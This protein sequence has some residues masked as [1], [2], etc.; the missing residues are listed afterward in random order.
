MLHNHIDEAGKTAPHLNFKSGGDDVSGEYL[1]GKLA[2]QRLT[3]IVCRSAGRRGGSGRPERVGPK[4]GRPERRDDVPQFHQSGG[5]D[6][7]LYYNWI[8]IN[9][10][11]RPPR[12][13]PSSDLLER[14]PREFPSQLNKRLR[15]N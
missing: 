12:A 14:P 8:Y 1:S 3:G 4:R 11:E 13:T 5:D 10:L 15:R 9:S 6:K 2:S 7:Q